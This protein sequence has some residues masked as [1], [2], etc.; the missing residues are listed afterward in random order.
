M[1]GCVRMAP[2]A[3]LDG[4][5][6]ECEAQVRRYAGASFR[7][8]A[9]LQEARTFV[10][11]GPAATGTAPPAAGAAADREVVYTDGC[12]LGNGGR[13][14]RGGIG[15]YWGPADPRNL[16]AP[17]PGE[18]QTNQRA[19]LEAALAAL[20]S[21]RESD[22]ALEIRTDSSYAVKAA[23]EWLPRWQQNGFRTVGG[24]PVKNADL[25]HR[26][27]HALR[28]RRRPVTWVRTAWAAARGAR[29][30]WGPPRGSDPRLWPH[31]GSWQ[32]VRRSAGTQRR[33]EPRQWSCVQAVCTVVC[34]VAP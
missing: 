14:A 30:D 3:Y 23:T 34:R 17:L 18:L 7:K 28:N 21:T 26:L 11:H 15:V 12:A 4:P 29:A 13:A 9:T 19:E 1:P 33:A 16:S 25:M 22:V 31:R 6:A 27:G 5:R 20:E 32:R 24:T 10:E 8:C 2:G